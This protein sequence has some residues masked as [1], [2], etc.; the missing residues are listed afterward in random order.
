MFF[1]KEV[2]EDSLQEISDDKKENIMLKQ[3]VTEANNGYVKI[4]NEIEISKRRMELTLMVL[5][6]YSEEGTTIDIKIDDE[7]LAVANNVLRN[8]LENIATEQLKNKK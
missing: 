6:S 2:Q 8:E 7:V 4:F 3:L 1:R 5:E